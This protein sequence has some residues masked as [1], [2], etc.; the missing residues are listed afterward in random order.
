MA[1][2]VI[3]REAE[4]AAVYAAVLAPMGL[5]GVAM[6]VTCTAPARDPGELGGGGGGG[7]VGGRRGGWLFIKKNSPS[8][9]I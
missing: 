9:H 1:Y 7:G 6:P 8:P 4:A 2:A 5:E 3:T